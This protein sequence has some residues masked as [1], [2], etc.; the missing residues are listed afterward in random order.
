MSNI[1][2][3]YQG[4]II[5]AEFEDD[6]LRQSAQYSPYDAIYDTHRLFQ[7]AVNYHIVALAGMCQ[8]KAVPIAAEFEARIKSIWTTKPKNAI[9]AENQSYHD[10]RHL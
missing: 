3:I 4:R 1:N 5:N 6:D 7:D 9:L 2:R 10:G 8:G